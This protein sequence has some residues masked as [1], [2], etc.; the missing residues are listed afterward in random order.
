[1]T[2]FDKVEEAIG[3][4][5]HLQKELGKLKAIQVQSTVF[6]SNIKLVVRTWFEKTRSSL[7]IRQEL[8]R[9]IDT[10]YQS[11][12][13]L[14]TAKSLK[15]KYK[16]VLSNLRTALA[17]LQSNHCLVNTLDTENGDVAP[18]FSNFI[19]DKEMQEILIRR[20]AECSFC[21]K[22]RQAPLS[23]IVMMGG[24][25]EGL[26]LV[27]ILEA[28]TKKVFAAK[29]IPKDKSTGK[30]LNLKEWTLNTYIDVAKEMG[31]ITQTGKDI[32]IVLRDY[33]NFI[34]PQKEYSEKV[35]VSSDDATMLW[36]VCKSISRQILSVIA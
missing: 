36:E 31:W 3:S 13:E 11:L 10:L 26:M 23:A 5:G 1:M 27:R 34:H 2:A 25:L 35:S 20:W 19:R 9:P 18:D 29:S 6:R 28:D 16:T 22:S 15:T 24:M 4:V 7:Q 12:L 14:S 30:A 21:I 33:R 8:L 17:S 32:S